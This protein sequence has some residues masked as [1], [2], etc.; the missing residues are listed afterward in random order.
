MTNYG[1]ELRMGGDIRKKRKVKSMMEFIERMRKV[2][3]E[4][5]VALKKM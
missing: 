2:H 1:R 3:E 5:G 4:A